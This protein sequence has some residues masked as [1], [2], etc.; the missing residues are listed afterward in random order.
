MVEFSNSSALW[1]WHMER[2][3]LVHR[4]G[5][6]R[7]DY[8]RRY[9]DADLEIVLRLST[10]FNVPYYRLYAVVNGKSRF[11]IDR[12]EKEIQQV[13]KFISFHTGWRGV[14]HHVQWRGS[15]SGR[16]VGNP[17]TTAPTSA[18]IRGRVPH[19]SRCNAQSGSSARTCNHKVAFYVAV[20]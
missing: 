11:L 16:V 5:I 14:S 9:Q 2:N 1:V 12:G 10:K 7:L 4:V 8:S 19:V 15:Y 18:R 17:P 6:G 20:S 13:A 3:C